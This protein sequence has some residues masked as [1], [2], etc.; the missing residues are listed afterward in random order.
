VKSRAYD[1]S[2]NVGTSA[3]VSIYVNN[4][5]KDTTAPTVTITAT[6]DS[7]GVVTL[8]ASAT[9]NVGIT[10]IEFYVDGK[11]N[12]TDTAAPF[13]TSLRLTG[14]SGSNHT[15]VAKAYDAAGNVGASSLLTLT[16]K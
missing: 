8:L 6:M 16:K 9:D 15:A 3:D 12:A 2:G 10:R 11:L 1:G 5:P 13:A 14:P 4:L 7:K